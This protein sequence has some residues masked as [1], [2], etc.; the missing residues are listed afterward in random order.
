MSCP[1]FE[2]KI[3]RYAGGDLEPAEIRT[4]EGHLRQ[5]AACAELA[6][7]LEQDR[8]WLGSRPP[9][10]ADMDY[11]AM[12]SQIRRAIVHRRGARRWAWALAAAAAVL[13]AT[14]VGMTR[15]APRETVTVAGVRTGAAQEAMTGPTVAEDVPAVQPAPARVPARHAMVRAPQ[16]RYRSIHASILRLSAT[17][18]LMP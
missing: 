4:V 3:A 11:A 18:A 14:G 7:L 10:A 1:S 9:E 15:R 5:C 17:P 6:R 2:E 16:R 12:R 8:A 13:L